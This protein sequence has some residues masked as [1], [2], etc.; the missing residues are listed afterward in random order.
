MIR[1]FTC[2]ESPQERYQYTIQSRVI[3]R[4]CS[5]VITG[6]SD[7]KTIN[8]LECTNQTATQASVSPVVVFIFRPASMREISWYQLPRVSVVPRRW[9]TPSPRISLSLGRFFTSIFC[10]SLE[11]FPTSSLSRKQMCLSCKQMCWCE[12]CCLNEKLIYFT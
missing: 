2:Q 10:H 1:I 4:T 9:D 5:S 11:F 3:C 7:S 12:H 8:T 6:R